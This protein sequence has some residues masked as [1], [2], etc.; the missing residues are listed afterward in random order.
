M[1]NVTPRLA[2]LAFAGFLIWLG[3]FGAPATAAE[4]ATTTAPP[5]ARLGEK[6]GE[7][8]G[9]I[10]ACR[11]VAPTFAPTTQLRAPLDPVRFAGGAKRHFLVAAPCPR[12]RPPF[13]V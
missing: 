12:A 6:L 4:A 11:I 13:D 2:S 1:S 8:L 7:K 3:G 10:D 9:E 5:A